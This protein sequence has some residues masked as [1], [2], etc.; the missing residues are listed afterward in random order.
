MAG[1]GEPTTGATVGD[2]QVGHLST[3][4]MPT[5]VSVSHTGGGAPPPRAPDRRAG[6]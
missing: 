2:L 5:G 1:D 4:P 3:G 6:T